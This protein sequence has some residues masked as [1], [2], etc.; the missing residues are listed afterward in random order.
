LIRFCGGNNQDLAGSCAFDRRDPRTSTCGSSEIALTCDHL[1]FAWCERTIFDHPEVPFGL[2]TAGGG[3]ERLARFVGRARALEIVIGG[4]NFGLTSGWRSQSAMDGIA[5]AP[6]D[7]Y[8]DSRWIAGTGLI[9]R[10]RLSSSQPE[11]PQSPSSICSHIARSAAPESYLYVVL[12]NQVAVSAFDVDGYRL[13][14]GR[15]RILQLIGAV[16]VPNTPVEQPDHDRHQVGASRG[17]HVLVPR[18]DASLLV[19]TAF[20]K[21]GFREPAQVGGRSRRCHPT[22]STKSSNRRVP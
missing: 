13:A 15:V 7:G 22:R 14:A 8:H 21:T 12:A 1:H 18:P 10:A 9:L 11:Q 5:G 3:I 16:G 6:R 20:Q 17:E 2:L 4:V 19:G